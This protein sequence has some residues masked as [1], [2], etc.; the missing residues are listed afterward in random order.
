[1]GGFFVGAID[2]TRSNIIPADASQTG[3]RYALI[4]SPKSMEPPLERNYMWPG[5]VSPPPTR[6]RWDGL[7]ATQSMASATYPAAEHCLGLSYPSDGASQWYLPAMDELELIY[8]NL[9]PTTRNNTVSVSGGHEF[10]GGVQAYGYNPS[11]VITGAAYTQSAPGQTSAVAFRDGGV[12]ALEA[13]YW[14]STEFSDSYA[15]F[16]RF[17]G[18][19]SGYQN[20]SLKG[21][22][23]RV[24]PVRRLIL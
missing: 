22:V 8:R 6:T 11:S 14:S 21:S 2:T 12:Q 3:L 15:W 23:H 9:K 18:Q 10:P 16:H 19:T 7:S 4:V 1:M 5:D 17:S 20:E 13:S 24:R